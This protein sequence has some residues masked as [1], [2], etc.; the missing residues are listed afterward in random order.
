MRE[1]DFGKPMK[2]AEVFSKISMM[3]LTLFDTSLRRSERYMEA[4]IGWGRILLVQFQILVVYKTVV[5]F[6]ACL[7][8]YTPIYTMAEPILG[9]FAF[10]S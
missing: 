4:H 2:A 6:D 7:S 9:L 3:M 10:F 1:L 5:P 8:P